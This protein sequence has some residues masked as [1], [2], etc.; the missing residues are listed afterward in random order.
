MLLA[1][2]VCTMSYSAEKKAKLP[3]NGTAEAP[4][5]VTVSNF[6]ELQKYLKK[7]YMQLTMTPGT[8][9]IT[10]ADIKAGKYPGQSE[11]TEGRVKNVIMPITGN[12]ST[13]DFTGV[14]LEIETAVFNAFENKGELH[15][16]HVL[17]NNN[18]V[19][20]LKIIDVGRPID[21]P[22]SGCTN[23]AIDGANNRLEGVEVRSQGSYPYGYG[24]LFG[25]GG[26]G[27]VIRHKKHCCCLLRGDNNYLKD[28]KFYH[29]AFGHII[30]MQGAVNPTIEGCHAEGKVNTT[31]RVLAEK[32]TGS[33][34][35]KVNFMT[36]YGYVTPPGYTFPV[37]EDG[38]RTYGSGDT[39]IDGVRYGKRATSGDI[40]VKDCTVKYARRGISLTHENGKKHVENCTLIGCK[41]GYSL[42]SGKVI[43]CRAD[44]AFGPAIWF[45]YNNIRGVEMD[46]TL[47][48]PTGE[49]HTGNKSGQAVIIAGH[50]NKITLRKGEG[51][52]PDEELGIYIGG[53][54]R[55]LG[56]L[57]EVS[58]NPANNNTIINETDYIVIVDDNTSGNKITTAGEYTDEGKD[59]TITKM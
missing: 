21:I 37:C 35:D 58:N 24:S 4:L 53:D 11:V 50:N 20:N 6:V 40:V 38:I 57:K 34:A 59:N 22:Q 15:D 7:N 28:C 44:A 41:S 36:S 19:K 32:G 3:K 33:A 52:Q 48:P 12:N 55:A 18:I 9:R 16:I 43:N 56:H 46:V 30:F 51:L 5:V 45:M 39:M 1:V 42:N 2:G 31:D 29:N 23:I 49:R 13:Y 8:Y 25:I 10:A 54:C 14:T 17:G 27:T 47:I 26:K